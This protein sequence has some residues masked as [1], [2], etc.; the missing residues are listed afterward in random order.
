M[1]ILL[2]NKFYYLK[3]GTER[4]VFDLKNLLESKNHQVV[5][6]SMLDIRNF[7]SKYAE[8]FVS[9]V[10]LERPGFSFRDLKTASRIIYSFEAKK[11]IEALVKKV[12][13]DIVH[14]HNIY[15][16]ISPSILTVL[17]KCNIPI[18]QTLHDYKLIC[19]AYILYSKGE[20]CERCKRYRY[21]MCTLRKC[22]K[23]SRSA[24]FI[25]TIEMYFHKFLKIYEN[26][27]D[28]FVAPSNFLRDKIL[29]WGI[30]K[31]EQIVTIPHFIDLS[32]YALNRQIE[33][34]AKSNQYFLYF[35]RFSK[36]KGLTDL[37]SAMNYVKKGRLLFAGEGPEEKKLKEQVRQRDLSNVEFLGH[38]DQKELI[39]VIAKSLFTIL[40]SVVYESFG[41]TILESYALGKPVIG[42]DSGAIP[43]LIE[44]QK[45]G[46]IFQAGNS[47]DL[48]EKINFMMKNKDKV[49]EMGRRARFKVER[50]FT[51]ARYYEKLMEVYQEVVKYQK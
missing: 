16:Q 8:Y 9:N 32:R 50:E 21:Y 30:L 17:K 44:D 38:L 41:L 19:P 25:N 6:F 20:I 27:V 45:T 10:E 28:V 5:P 11:K 35:G 14:I 12:R 3:G 24:S 37:I 46:L 39:Q 1:K 22:T 26:N 43:E 51:S 23:N 29:E 42:S 36:E 47:R 48:V 49:L 13:P 7:K 33:T 40:P 4:H 15:H 31:P 18:V 34:E 2:A